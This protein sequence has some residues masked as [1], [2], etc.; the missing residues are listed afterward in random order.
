[1]SPG[2]RESYKLEKLWKNAKT[3][4]PKILKVNSKKQIASIENKP[5]KPKK[6]KIKYKK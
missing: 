5:T 4:E 2:I 1:M 3:I 6:L